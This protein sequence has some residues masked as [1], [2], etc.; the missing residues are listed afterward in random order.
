MQTLM[1]NE[2][3]DVSGGVIPA[4]L[5]GIAGAYIYDAVGGK[6]G[7]DEYVEKSVASAS[8]SI[9]YWHNQLT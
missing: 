9:E 8:A 6:E 4:I 5:A 7:I 2:V 3:E 1:A